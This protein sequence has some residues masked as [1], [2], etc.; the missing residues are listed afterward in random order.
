MRSLSLWFKLCRPHHCVGAATGTWL[1]A[2]LS[3][4]PHWIT[5]PKAAAA[6]TMAL[7]VFGASIYHYGAAHPMYAR[8]GEQIAGLNTRALVTLGILVMGISILLAATFLPWMCG[9]F[10]LI[11]AAIILLYPPVE[12]IACAIH[13]EA[14]DNS[15]AIGVGVGVIDG[16]IP[17]RTSSSQVRCA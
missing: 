9:I 6:G 12:E 17:D 1:S 4:G 16:G 5:V 3:N 15:G 10:V 8:K 2:M 14:S 7:A 11:D 13:G